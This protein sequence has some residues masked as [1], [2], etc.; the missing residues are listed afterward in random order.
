MNRLIVGTMTWGEWGRKFSTKEAA[1]LIQDC[2]ALGLRSFD[3]ADIY[4]GYSTEAEFGKAFQ[5]SGIAREE[6]IHISKC[7]IQM[8]CD[9]RP[10]KVKHYDYSKEHIIASAEN[11]LSHLQTDY[12]DVLLLHR[13]S[14]LMQ[15][16][17]IAAAFSLLTSSGKVKSFGVSNFTPSQ[18]Q[19]LQKEVDLEWN[20]IECSLSHNQP[21]F[22]GSLDFHLSENIGSMAW[23]PLGDY[24]K[25]DSPAKA[26]LQLL[27]Q[28]LCEVYKA[29]EDQLLLAWLLRH[30]AH[31]HPVLGTTRLER[32]SASVAAEKIDLSLTD[33]FRLLEA[34]WGHEVP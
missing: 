13:P 28:E 34:Q 30:P 25:E 24:F 19:Y 23:S 7:G 3:H 26:R 33:W 29:S 16:E 21:L 10:L 14:P 22:D 31:I 1:K 20:Q 32:L 11:S 18:I 15:V 9:A 5:A 8:P 2:V 27:F 4:G 6:V 17:E 12:L